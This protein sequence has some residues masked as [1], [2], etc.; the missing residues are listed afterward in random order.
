M[1]RLSGRLY[2]LVAALVLACLPVANRDWAFAASVVSG[3]NDVNTQPVRW[4]I[5][6]SSNV[7]ADIKK[8]LVTNPAAIKAII[9]VV[10]E[11]GLSPEQIAAISSGMNLAR[12][13]LLASGQAVAAS[14]I[15][16]AQSAEPALSQGSAPSVIKPQVSA[17]SANTTNDGE[18]APE[19]DAPA[20]DP[21]PEVVTDPQMVNVPDY[22][23]VPAPTGQGPNSDG[24]T[25]SDGWKPS[26]GTSVSSNGWNTSVGT[27]NSSNGYRVAGP[28]SYTP[29]GGSQQSSAPPPPPPPYF[30]SDSNGLNSANSMSG[31]SSNI[32]NSAVIFSSAYVDPTSAL[33][34][35][36]KLTGTPSNPVSP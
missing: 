18:N 4:I 31:T 5:K 23:R 6:T 25:S 2:A 15:L 20:S 22:S 21:V 28:S 29:P 11:G 14:E 35:A 19:G 30:V 27:N 32:F 36:N 3:Q 7:A 12:S 16:A 8:L 24:S 33:N 13:Q 26:V 10:K 34:V 1:S 9:A 17:Q